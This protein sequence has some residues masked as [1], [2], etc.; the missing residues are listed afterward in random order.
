MYVQVLL[1]SV[2]PLL[3]LAFLNGA[4]IVSLRQANLYLSRN[5]PSGS[6]AKVNVHREQTKVSWRCLSQAGVKKRSDTA[7]TEQQSKESSRILYSKIAIWNK[8][9]MK[10][11]FSTNGFSKKFFYRIKCKTLVFNKARRATIFG[12]K[13]PF[14]SLLASIVLFSHSLS[15]PT[16]CVISSI[17]LYITV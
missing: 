9:G 11:D 3:L 10:V 14:V 16:S 2:I 15:R 17:A 13:N 12:E 4:I 6:Q 7:T 1:L 8:L 5:L